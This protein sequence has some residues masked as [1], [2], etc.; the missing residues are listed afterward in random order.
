[1]FSPRKI[2]KARL[3]R[4]KALRFV[5]QMRLLNNCLIE[6]RSQG[7]VE[8][9]TGGNCTDRCIAR[10]RLLCGVNHP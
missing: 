4:C 1:M 3:N 6:L 10:E 9:P 8:I 2:R 5:V 7:G